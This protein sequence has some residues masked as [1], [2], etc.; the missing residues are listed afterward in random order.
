MRANA[1]VGRDVSRGQGK[2]V[3]VL[4]GARSGKS[5]FAVSCAVASGRPVTY[6]ATATAGDAE[7]AERIT[8]HR[9]DRPSGWATVEQPRW[10]GPALRPLAG[11]G[12]TIIVDCLTLLVANALLGGTGPASAGG[13]P[14]EAGEGPA[15]AEAEVTDFIEA[16]CAARD[17]GALVFVVSN[18]VGLGLVPP[19]PLGRLYRDTLGRAN[20]VLAGA[21]D[22]VYLMIAGIPLDLRAALGCRTDG[23]RFGEERDERGETMVTTRAAR[24]LKPWG[25]NA[26][27][28]A[29]PAVLVALSAVGSFIKIPSLIGTP[30]LDSA[31]G[32]F[33][34][35]VLGAGPGA[36]VA[37]I[38]HLLTALSAGFPLGLPIHGLIAAGMAGCAAATAILRRLAGP[39]VAC[40]GGVLLNGIALPA[41]FVLVPGFGPAFFLAMVVPL[42]VASL[43]NVGLAGA[44]SVAAGRAGWGIRSR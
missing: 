13:A 15:G 41:A 34:A 23:A 44:A 16:A 29:L 1:R 38:G 39:W 33:A 43:L 6:V 14:G 18:E 24:D 42:L 7:M 10:V 2:L 3:L 19:Y 12:K 22:Q 40:A 32:Y 5:D 25:P 21:A 27:R 9:R 35:L 11:P 26:R 4:G 36:A 31:P 30:A 17:A 8:R 28:L 37:G 20:R